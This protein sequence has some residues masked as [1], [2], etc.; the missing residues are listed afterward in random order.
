LRLGRSAA[1]RVAAR[2]FGFSGSLRAICMKS[3][4]DTYNKR[5]ANIK[6]CVDSLLDGRLSQ[7]VR[8]ALFRVYMPVIEKEDKYTGAHN[9]WSGVNVLS[10][11]VRLLRRLQ[12]TV[13]ADEEEKLMQEQ[14]L[15][16]TAWK[17]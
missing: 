1:R 9:G 8:H 3:S 15:M 6:V 2:R 17:A 16:V 13:I 5:A 4:R 10:V 7:G 12:H 11:I 14:A